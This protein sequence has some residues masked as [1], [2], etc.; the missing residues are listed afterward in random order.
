MA[1]NASERQWTDMMKAM[2]AGLALVASASGQGSGVIL[3]VG[4]FSEST[5]TAD[6]ASPFWQ[7][8]QPVVA[9]ADQLGQPTP[10]HRTEIRS[11]WTKQNLYILFVCPYQ[12]LNLK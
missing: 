1:A 5:L 9:T 7:A 12:Q 11:R 8:T 6:P 3:S 10:S 4:S 2:I